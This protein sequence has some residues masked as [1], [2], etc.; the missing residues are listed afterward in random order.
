MH[1]PSSG[2][3]KVRMTMDRRKI[4]EKLVKLRG[5]RTREEVA[6]G[7]KITFRQLES[8]EAG[9]RLPRDDVKMRLAKFYDVSIEDLFYEA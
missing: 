2:E 7:A 4:G 1:E 6:V 3:K 8:Y 9:I 5:S